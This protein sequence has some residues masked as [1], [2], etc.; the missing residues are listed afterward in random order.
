MRHKGIFSKPNI[1]SFDESEDVVFVLCEEGIHA[2]LPD[3][4]NPKGPAEFMALPIHQRYGLI[5]NALMHDVDRFEVTMRA[6]MLLEALTSRVPEDEMA[7]ALDTVL[8]LIQEIGSE[9]AEGPTGMEE[10]VAEAMRNGT[11]LCSWMKGD[12]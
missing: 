12:G 1:C 5:L 9:D 8:D 7:N 11:L 4:L 10:R 2:S 3:D 6:V